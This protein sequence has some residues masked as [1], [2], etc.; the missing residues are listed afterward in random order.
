MAVSR[1]FTVAVLAPGG[2]VNAVVWVHPGP[3]IVIM[4]S[5]FSGRTRGGQA[6]EIPITPDE[7]AANGRKVRDVFRSYH[8][9]ILARAREEAFA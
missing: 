5:Y 3:E 9:L 4:R 7:L 8:D 2:V 6:V 1:T